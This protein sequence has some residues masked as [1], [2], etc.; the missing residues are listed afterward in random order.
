MNRNEALLGS[1]NKWRPPEGRQSLH[2]T[3]ETTGWGVTLTADHSD[4]LGC[5]IWELALRKNAVAA[6]PLN[7]W[8]ARVADRATGLLE[9][10][11]VVEVDPGRGEALLRS[12][13]PACHGEQAAYYEVILGVVGSATLRRFTAPRNGTGKRE[14][15]AFALTHEAVAKLAYDLTDAA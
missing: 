10:M 14:Q 15:T 9:T 13:S 4:R 3:D 11:K 5:L 12:E 2:V 6:L 7:Q 1:L 8:A